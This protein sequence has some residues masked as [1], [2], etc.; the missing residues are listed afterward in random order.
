[1]TSCMGT[2]DV[3]LKQY[4]RVYMKK[5]IIIRVVRVLGIRHHRGSESRCS[6]SSRGI[7]LLN[8]GKKSNRRRLGGFFKKLGKWLFYIIMVIINAFEKITDFVSFILDF[9]NW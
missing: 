8:D 3:A 9:L 4:A 6:I 1:M 2:G 5:I 7:V